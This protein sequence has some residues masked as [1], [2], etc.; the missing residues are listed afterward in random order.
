[1]LCMWVREFCMLELM[2][3]FNYFSR[4][5][6]AE[7]RVFVPSVSQSSP[8]LPV[9]AIARANKEVEVVSVG[10]SRAP[11]NYSPSQQE[12]I[13]KYAAMQGP[14]AASWHISSRLGH[15]VPESTARK[16][17]DLYRAELERRKRKALDEYTAISCVAELPPKNV[18][19][20]CCYKTWTVR[21]KNT[22]EN[23]V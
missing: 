5:M 12:D 9:Q 3:I 23:F 8:N 2:S 16:F 6:P 19:D 13:G 21:F 20:L 15:P 7:R 4:Q 1:M 11:A 18:G 17:R 14:T 22:W 10:Q